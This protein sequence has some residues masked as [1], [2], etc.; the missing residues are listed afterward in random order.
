MRKTK[1]AARQG[2]KFKRLAYEL[3]HQASRL[4][5]AGLEREAEALKAA[6]NSCAF[7][8]N[9]ILERSDK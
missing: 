8:G 5:A 9:S 1:I 6:S 2:E 3:E 7:V 4:R